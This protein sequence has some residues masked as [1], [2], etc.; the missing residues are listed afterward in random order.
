MSEFEKEQFEQLKFEE[1]E[2]I[3]DLSKIPKVEAFEFNNTREFNKIASE[4]AQFDP[5]FNL[6]QPH[7][8]I[9]ENFLEK[10]DHKL[11]LAKGK[12]NE[13]IGYALYMP[14]SHYLKHVEA[15]PIGYSVEKSYKRDIRSSLINEIQKKS[16]YLW[17]LNY[18]SLMFKNDIGALLGTGFEKTIKKLKRYGKTI[19]KD[20]YIWS[21][22]EDNE[23]RLK[24]IL[25]K[26]K[27]C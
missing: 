3:G 21:Q 11:F 2:R 9:I 5:K 7:R 24:K 18:D 25:R 1:V 20:F 19:P 10:G 15:K 6:E 13:I 4:I 17:A 27:Y 12:N 23:Q 8:D 26:I 14:Q 22:G 16:G